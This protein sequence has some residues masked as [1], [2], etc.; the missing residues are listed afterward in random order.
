[1]RIL[2]LSA[3]GGTPADSVAALRPLAAAALSA[4][5]ADM[6]E[7]EAFLAGQGVDRRF[8]LPSPDDTPS[9]TSCAAAATSDAERPAFE[10]E[11]LD[12]RAGLDGGRAR[13]PHDQAIGVRQVGEHGAVL[14]I[15]GCRDEASV[16]IMREPGAQVVLPAVVLGQ[17]AA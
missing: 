13:S 1:R 12:D 5:E 11:D 3:G 4:L 10:P 2:G 15:E 8:S 17:V 16:R 9:S 7:M 14:A 6:H